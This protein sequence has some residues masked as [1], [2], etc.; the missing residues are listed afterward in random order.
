MPVPDALAP[1]S[2]QATGRVLTIQ[3]VAKRSW[4]EGLEGLA[5]HDDD[6]LPQ[7]KHF[8]TL[9]R[10]GYHLSHIASLDEL[11]QLIL[12]D[13]VAVLRAQH[14]CI[15][16]VNP[17]NGELSLRGLSMDPKLRRWRSISVGP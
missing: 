13:T 7:G 5:Q 15:L 14:G 6:R 4:E 10:G 9:L 17:L 11:L 12:G 8:L 3:A 2:V 16:L 1:S